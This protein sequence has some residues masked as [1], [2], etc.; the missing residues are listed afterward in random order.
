MKKTA[1]AYLKTKA[2]S[3]KNS[4]LMAFE[5]LLNKSV[6]IGDHSTGDFTKN[7]DEALQQLVDA[8]DKLETVEWLENK[9]NTKQEQ[10]VLNF[11]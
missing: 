7:L 10:Y 8:N 1:L 2:L 4:A 11:E 6:G 3:E 5:L 9:F